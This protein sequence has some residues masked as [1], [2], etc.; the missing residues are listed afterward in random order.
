MLFMEGHA[1]TT[2]MTGEPR[3]KLIEFGY[4]LKILR[5]RR[6]ISQEWLGRETGL[7]RVAIS[8]LETGKSCPTA[9]SLERLADVLGVTMDELWRGLDRRAAR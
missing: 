5:S 3:D 6:E 2:T 9:S 1:M 4:R 7:T 8:C